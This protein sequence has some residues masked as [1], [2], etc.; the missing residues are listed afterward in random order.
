MPVTNVTVGALPQT[1]SLRQ[2][3]TPEGVALTVRL[4]DRG[5][6]AAA[7]LLDLLF[8]F[9]AILGLTL[10]IVF[11]V[12]LGGMGGAWELG[13][14]LYFLMFFAIRSFYFIFFE[15]RWDG[16]TPGKRIMKLRVIDRHGGPLTADAV[17]ARNLMREVELFLPMTVLLAEPMGPT[18]AWI[19]LLNIVWLSILVFMPFFNRDRLRA[20]DM[21]AGTWVIA[22]PKATL[23]REMANETAV[24]SSAALTDE[25]AFR[26]TS[27]ELGVYGI[28]ELQIL[29]D[30]LRDSGQEVRLEVAK[31]IAAKIGWPEADIGTDPKPFLEAFYTAL[32]AELEGKMLFGVRRKDKFDNGDTMPGG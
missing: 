8:I 17:F 9:G 28:H 7:V 20:G 3:V 14:I 16:V 31:R 12:S 11:A 25:P 23:E 26:F 5:E 22:A 24:A 10:V 21:I 1:K 4:A 6:R 13:A 32:R 30:V 19:M 18:G 15:L 29:E 27:Q 2:I